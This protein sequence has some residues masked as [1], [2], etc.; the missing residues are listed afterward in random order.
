VT[1]H[2]GEVT[3]LFGK[4]TW[5]FKKVTRHSGKVTRRFQKV[6]RLFGKVTR[7][8]E[9]VIRQSGTVTESFGKVTMH[10]GKVEAESFGACEVRC[11]RWLF[12]NKRP[13]SL[14]QKAE[15]GVPGDRRTGP[16]APP[17]TVGRLRYLHEKECALTF[18]YYTH[19]RILYTTF[20]YATFV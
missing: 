11:W 19:L 14:S 16:L 15:W 17:D 8:F 13:V 7:H 3:R 20:V 9:T 6:V 12:G 5:L 10:V 1:G 2:F 18:V 4:V